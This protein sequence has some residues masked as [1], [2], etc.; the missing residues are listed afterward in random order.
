MSAWIVALARQVSAVSGSTMC[1]RDRLWDQ[2]EI[3]QELKL[4]I[5][6]SVQSLDICPTA[7]AIDGSKV[8][9]MN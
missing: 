9:P 4:F 6:V 5:P 2:L 3:D 1:D 7:R 8:F